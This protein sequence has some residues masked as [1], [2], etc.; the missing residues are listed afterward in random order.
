MSTSV[1]CRD[2]LPPV[3]GVERF[4]RLGVVVLMGIALIGGWT[5]VASASCGDYLAHSEKPVFLT[6]DAQVGNQ[7]KV[8]NSTAK[9]FQTPDRPCS[10]PNCSRG[11]LPP[12]SVPPAGLIQVSDQAALRESLSSVSPPDHAAVIPESE[13]GTRY[14]PSSIFRP[15]TA[16]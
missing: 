15:P 8:G 7:A 2:A 1:R 11:S 5:S 14:E 10:G 12:A 16:A 6:D 4:L 13:R 3:L 9:P